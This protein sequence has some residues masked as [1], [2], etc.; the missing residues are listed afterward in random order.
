MTLSPIGSDPKHQWPDKV[1]ESLLSDLMISD[2]KHKID[3]SQY[4]N[5][6]NVSLQHYLIKMIHRILSAVDN[7][8]KR[9][10][11]AVVANLID[12]KQA[13]SRQCPKLGI[14][15]FIENN[16][17]SSLISLLENYFQDRVM[18]E[19]HHGV[20]SVPRELNGG[21]PEGGTLGILE[22]LS[23]SNKS[24]DCVGPD[25]RFKF[26]DDLTVLET[27]NLLTVGLTSFN[28]KHEV[29]ADLPEHGQYIPAENLKSQDYLNQIN[30]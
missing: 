5:Q 12:W 13:F 9:E 17:R 10:T 11:F 29:P 22:Y 15:S 7:N 30:E 4:G 2:M 19:K 18:V 14:L 16:V 25:D 8:T 23:Q 21:G 27:V 24:A 26:V 28:V 6:K 1:V 20:T 3:Q